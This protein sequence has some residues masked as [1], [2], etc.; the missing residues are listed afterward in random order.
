MDEQGAHKEEAQPLALP[1]PKDESGQSGT[2]RERTP[3]QL[4]R[5]EKAYD[6]HISGKTYRQIAE[7]LSCDKDTVTTDIRAEQQR[8]ADEIA[9]R[10]EVEKARAVSLYERV[11]DRALK[12]SDIYDELVMQPGAKVTDRTLEAVI[13]ARERIDKV[14]GVDAPTKIDLGLDKLFTAFDDQG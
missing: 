10:R 14:L 1:A 12:K 5:Q 9:E 11:I 8:R 3:A 13:H 7:I 2:T 4:E 6:L